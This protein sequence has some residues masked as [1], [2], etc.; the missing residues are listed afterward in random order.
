MRLSAPEICRSI[1][2]ICNADS[3][4]LILLIIYSQGIFKDIKNP[5]N[6]DYHEWVKRINVFYLTKMHHVMCV[7]EIDEYFKAI[8][9]RGMFIIY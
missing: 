2:L 1:N 8:L 6:N 3:P 9:S 5:N 7:Q 4:I